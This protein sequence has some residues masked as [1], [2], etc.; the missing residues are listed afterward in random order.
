MVGGT[1]VR[2]DSDAREGRF[3]KSRFH[4][5]YTI[6]FYRSLVTTKLKCDR[7]RNKLRFQL[8]PHFSIN[9]MPLPPHQIYCYYYYNYY[10]VIAEQAYKF[11]ILNAIVRTMSWKVGS[12]PRGLALIGSHDQ[13][14]DSNQIKLLVISSSKLLTPYP[15]YLLKFSIFYFLLLT[16]LEK[17]NSKLA[18]R[19][20]QVTHSLNS[21][22]ILREVIISSFLNDQQPHKSINARRFHKHSTSS[23][24]LVQLTSNSLNYAFA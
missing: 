10:N 11:H 8:T 21:S 7:H 24:A 22:T 20:L 18:K 6:I 5:Y 2:S 9:S 17:C 1:E 4:S 3:I 19:T 12:H 15:N 14:W 23:N 13:Q 16:K